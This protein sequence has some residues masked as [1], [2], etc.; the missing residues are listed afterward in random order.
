MQLDANPAAVF[1]FSWVYDLPFGKGKSLLNVDSRAVNAAVSGWKLN[2]V[3]KYNSGAPL[4]I[5]AGA[6]R[7]SSVGYS[8]RGNA[9]LNVS[10]YITTNPRELVPLTGKYLNSAAFTTTT[11]F[12]FGNLAP[13]LSW[14]RGFWGKYEALTLGRTFSVTERL[15][16]DFSADAVNP[17]NF[18]RWANPNTN[19]V[20]TSFGTVNATDA[21]GGRTLQL[22]A[23]VRF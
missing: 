9:V 7:L 22:N 4:G 16:L 10:P 1:S 18:H 2:G 15:K 6:G 14:V 8:Q 3:M 21:T 5:A 13:T 11:G 17:F 12:D 19:V 23:A 20:S